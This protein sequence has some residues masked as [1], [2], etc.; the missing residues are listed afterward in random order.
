MATLGG[1]ARRNPRGADFKRLSV[2]GGDLLY[3]IRKAPVSVNPPDIVVA[4]ANTGSVAVTVAGVAVGDVVYAVPPTDLE[5]DLLLKGAVVTN[6]DEVT[7]YFYAGANVNGA[8]K[9]WTL[10]VHE[11]S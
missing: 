9:N 5:D 7:F 11:F 1:S 6:T 4:T 10:L 8:A 3:K 2:G